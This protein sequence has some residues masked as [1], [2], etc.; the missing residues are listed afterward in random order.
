MV[1]EGDQVKLVGEF[2]ER[3]LEGEFEGFIHEKTTGVRV[4][5]EEVCVR[6][7]PYSGQ[8]LRQ[9]TSATEWLVRSP[10]EEH[11]ALRKES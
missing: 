4:L 7:N 11:A 3:V 8:R 6:K 5:V 1:L 2:G 10:E 9:N